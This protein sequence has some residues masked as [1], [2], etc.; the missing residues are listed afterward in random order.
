MFRKIGIRLKLII[1]FVILYLIAVAVGLTGIR[2][3]KST[4]RSEAA[5]VQN[6]FPATQFLGGMKEA[7]LNVMVG[8]SGLMVS[9]M[10]TGDL[11]QS[12]YEYIEK[13]KAGVMTAIEGYEKLPRDPEME[14][15]WQEFLKTKTE[16]D[17]KNQVIV[18]LAKERDN[19]IA[20]GTPSDDPAITDLDKRTFEASLDYREAG[21]RAYSEINSIVNLEN[22]QTETELRGNVKSGKRAILMVVVL[23]VLGFMAG[24][25]SSYLVAHSVMEILRAIRRQFKK[26]VEEVLEGRL[27][28]RADEMETNFEF[29]D[30]TKGLNDTLDAVVNP[31]NV[32]A[33]YLENISSGNMPEIITEKYKGDFNIIIG[34]L[35]RLIVTINEI[36]DKARKIAN[37]DLTV[38]LTKRSGQDDLIESLREMVNS[39]ARVISEFQTAAGNIS[40]SGE[41]MSSTSQSLS[42]GASEQASSAEEVSSSMEQMAANIQQNTENARQTEKIALNAADGINRLSDSSNL[43][44]KNMQ[45]IADKVSIIGEIARQTNI[46]A[47]NAAV[48]AARAGEH[49][50]GF[51]VVAAE[52]RKLA[53][54]SQVAAVEIDALTKT[55]VRATEESGALMAAIAPEIGRTAKLVQEITAASMEQNS[56]AEQVNNAIQQLNHVTQQNAAASEE[57]ATGSQELSSQAQ[58]LLELISFFRLN[59]DTGL[60]QTRTVSEKKQKYQTITSQAEQAKKRET[61][62]STV[63]KGVFINMDK[64]TSDADYDRF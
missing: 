21:L 45:D 57:M 38:E 36:T 17:Q 63:K 54:R 30:I 42:Q 64:D 20:A 53:E 41:Q 23:L 22:S 25:L 40:A 15:L 13:A 6:Q 56:G 24:Y 10:K 12:Q 4:L 19:L 35:N 48:E 18:D 62:R 59:N 52:V 49:G 61:S 43:V 2:G 32:S 7:Q 39:T 8:Q 58:Q 28:A 33:N 60:K 14:K 29:R 37:G 27:S 11:R 16:L 5:L 34:N 55:S 50:K 47:L 51:A 44:L 31:L 9:E 1:G 26:V 3:I 46:L